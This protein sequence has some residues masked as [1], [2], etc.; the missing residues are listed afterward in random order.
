MDASNNEI[1]LRGVNVNSLGEYYQVDPDYQTTFEMDDTDWRQM[2]ELGFS[3]VRLIVSW[4]M[5]EPSPG[6]ID[7]NYL[8]R[9]S[10]Y[11][12]RAAK[13]GMYTV[14]DMHQD[15]FS[16]FIYTKS[17]SECSANNS[18]GQRLNPAKG[19]DGAPAWATLTNGLNTCIDK[20]RNDSQAVN[21]AWNNFY[22]NTDGI[23]DHFIGAWEAIVERVGGRPEVAG[24]DL[25]NEPETSRPASQLT[26]SFTDLIR[27]TTLA[28]RATEDR[29]GFEPKIVFIEPAFG[30]G[31]PEYGVVV[32]SIE[33]GDPQMGPVVAAPHNYAEAIIG[34]TTIEGFNGL[35][36]GISDSLGIPVWIGEHGFWDTSSETLEKLKRYAIEEDARRW[37]GAWWQWRQG[38]GD[39][40]SVGWGGWSTN[41]A[42]TQDPDLIVHLNTVSCP[43]DK[44]VG[45]TLDL[46]R[47]VGRAYPRSAPGRL[48]SFV[49]DVEHETMNLSG[50]GAESGGRLAVF[51]PWG[52]ASI[53]ISSTG[54]SGVPQRISVGGG[55]PL[56]GAATIL[57][58]EAHGGDYSL[59]ISSK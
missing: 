59:Q 47:V 51:A 43:G 39:P 26:A 18:S 55:T 49:S 58:F 56:L 3:V 23:R 13:H 29:K 52:E 48:V 21:A 57:I 19:W 54:L 41:D 24:Y 32:P 15:A 44:R 38:C 42:T 40:H 10:D 2:Q 34:D 46:M 20:E 33:K 1:L 37:G 9:I 45:P 8:D 11:V 50:A 5:I 53:K 4:S 36:E 35:I 6:Q 12:D 17:S 14:I 22:D 25:L 31:H 27:S 28:I 30:A 7:Q 16:A